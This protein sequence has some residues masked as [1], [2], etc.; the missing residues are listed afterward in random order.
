MVLLGL[1]PHLAGSIVNVSYNA[2]L[3]VDKDP[4]QQS[5][6]HWLVMVYNTAAYPLILFV[7]VIVISRAHH[8]WRRLRDHAE[9]T[10]E[11]A[12]QS[13]GRALAL[14]GWIFALSCL[15]WFP[16]GVLFPTGLHYWAGP[17][18]MEVSIRFFLSFALSGLIA[19]T[20]AYFAAQ[21]VVLRVLYPQ[22]WSDPS[23]ARSV[24]QH[25]LHGLAPRLRRYQSLAILIPLLGAAMLISAG[26]DQLTLTFRLLVTSL[27]V[28]GLA[29]FALTT[30]VCN[31]LTLVLTLLTGREKD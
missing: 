19:S 20:Y 16:G 26:P 18:S 23:S 14:P 7:G 28:L 3:I 31:R 29:G 24:M 10:A 30:V 11:E 6:F 9:V 5:C 15:G 25:E 27:I 22:M 17:I 21:F 12:A 2:L 1:V 8:G 4:A 13:R